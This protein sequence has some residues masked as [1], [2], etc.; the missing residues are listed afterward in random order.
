MLFSAGNP[1]VIFGRQSACYFGW[2]CCFCQAYFCQACC[3]FCSMHVC[4]YLHNGLRLCYFCTKC[5]FWSGNPHIILVRQST[6]YFGQAIRM[7]FW[8]GNPHVI[9]VRHVVLSGMFVRHVAHSAACMC[10]CTC[11]MAYFYVA[12]V[13]SACFGQ[14]IRML[15]LSGNPHVI[16]VRQFACYFGQAIC[17]LF[18]SGMLFLS[19]MFLSG[20]LRILQHACACMY[21]HNGLCVDAAY[22]S[23]IVWLD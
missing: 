6:C 14:A 10:A 22:S 17:M 21:L 2:A 15:F 4:M 19:G 1:H 20:M 11:I 18:W 9:L 23:L 5:M 12:F 13:L 16:L 3:T 7:L 8:P